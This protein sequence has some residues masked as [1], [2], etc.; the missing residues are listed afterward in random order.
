[1]QASVI[2]SYYKNLPNLELVLLALEKQT[3]REDFEV[4]VSEDDDAPEL[5]LKLTCR[6]LAFEIFLEDIKMP[7]NTFATFFVCSCNC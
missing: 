7:Q 4:I 3:A 6:I 5:H 1:M 2:I